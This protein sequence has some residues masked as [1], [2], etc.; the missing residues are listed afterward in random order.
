MRRSCASLHKGRLRESP[1]RT[2]KV[3]GARVLVLVTQGAR[4]ENQAHVATGNNHP[5][6]Q[7]AGGFPPVDLLGAKSWIPLAVIFVVGCVLRF[8][9]FDRV[10]INPDE[11]IYYSMVTWTEWDSFWEEYSNNAHPPL[12]Y[13]VLRAMSTVT[14]DVSALRSIALVFGC[15][16]VIAMFLFARECV[17]R[18]AV[19]TL[20][21]LIAACLV[22]ISDTGIV[23]SQLIRP[24]SMQMALMTFGLYFLVRYIREPR[25]WLLPAYA[26]LMI[27][28]T[29]THYA[30]LLVIGGVAIACMVLLVSR[31]LDPRRVRSLLLWNLPLFV[32]VALCYWFHIRT[33]LDG[34]QIAIAAAN[35][36]LE[37]FMMDSLAEAWPLLLGLFSA[38]IQ[39]GF[40]GPVAVVFFAGLALAIYRKNLFLFAL[41]LATIAIAVMA[42]AAHKYPFGGSRHSVY[43]L[44][45]VALPVAFGV[46]SMLAGGRRAATAGSV[47]LVGLLGFHSPVTSMLGS[48]NFIRETE[49]TLRRSDLE[50]AHAFIDQEIETPGIV[51]MSMQ[52]YFGL[53]PKY[54]RERNL[55]RLSRDLVIGWFTWGRRTVVVLQ[56]W[57][58]QMSL[59]TMHN[60]DHLYNFIQNVDRQI[61]QLGLGEDKKALLLLGESSKILPDVLRLKNGPPGVKELVGR[62]VI[63][64]G[65]AAHIPNPPGFAAVEFDAAGYKAIVAEGLKARRGK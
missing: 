35:S 40:E 38:H 5:H 55:T 37:P 48:T 25:R 22:A 4:C 32:V 33:N 11:G 60:P 39:P 47:A 44:M 21:G 42:S 1:R 6:E 2:T 7:A 64:P 51:L 28:A 12:F 31:D 23:M 10:W 45:V 36:W 18:G 49:N 19:A 17:G 52:T 63:V 9:S 14:L 26:T 43:L 58:F 29:L 56:A 3:R 59:Q 54:H 15:G 20:T 65:F 41:P 57:T 16:W 46:A 13:L 24:Y 61:P 62:T 53:L 34:S 27:L 30:T 50:E 8:W